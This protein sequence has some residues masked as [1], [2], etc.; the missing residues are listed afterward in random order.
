MPHKVRAAGVTEQMGDIVLQCSGSYPGATLSGNLT[1]FLPVNI[2]NRVDSN[3]LTQDAILLV[4]YGTGFAPSGIPGKVSN[5]NIAFNGLNLTVPPSGNINLKITNLRANASQLGMSAPSKIAASISFTAVL[6]QATVVVAYPLAFFYAT[7]YDRGITCTG[8]PLPTTINLASLFAAQTAFVSTRATEGF[9]GA[10]LTRGST[11]DDGTR[12]LVK[13]SGFPSN[14]HIY[15]P[16]MV[17]G[18]DDY[19]PTAGGD[20]GVPQ[21]VGQYAPGSGTLLLVRVPF[22]DQTG[23]GGFPLATPTGSGP[24]SLNSVSEVPLLNGSGYAVYEV[25]DTN[26]A[27]IE[28]AQFPTFIALASV[29]VPAVAQESISLAPVSSVDVAS[30][31]APIPRFAATIP[32]SDCTILGDCQSSYFPKLSV[33]AAPIILSAFAGGAMNSQPG[34]VP[35]Q[36]QG[37]GVMNWT[38]TPTYKTGSGWLTLDYTSGQNNGSV[39]VWANP[40]GLAAGNYTAAI[41]IDAGPLAGN[42]TVPVTLTVTAITP[43]A[44]PVN[45][46][47]PPST[48]PPAAMAV[49]LVLN[50]ASLAP[51]PLVPGSLATLMGANLAGKKVSVTFDGA[52]ATV[53]Y[54]G[55]GQINLQVPASLGSKM[56]ATMV[57]TVDG[58]ST[59]P[60]VVGLSPAWPAIFSGGVLN[61][62]NSVNAAVAPAKARS[63]LQI[64][65]TGIPDGAAVSVQMAGRK[66]LPPL[67]AGGAPTVPGVQ[68]VNVAVPDDAETGTTQLV[69]CATAGGQQYC[70]PPYSLAVQ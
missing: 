56:S 9:A 6:N 53:L 39:R 24:V 11:E 38:A 57:V 19:V 25:V 2:T 60:V 54:D 52:A 33:Q 21:N 50:A 1:V 66:D 27:V 26:N 58:K 32:A 4:D 65:A 13:Y 23:A 10:F 69:V 37:G 49:T 42:V 59:I 44:P 62:D 12:F 70:S 48:P 35:I 18:S 31:T 43:P 40:T 47:P 51:A 63:V 61:Q 67:Y 36:N 28:S 45:P 64:Y 68:Q 29:T 46:P 34:Y 55:A 5:Q 30:P 20:L 22:A 16:D 17:A 3:N 7:L 15:I 8:S 41:V 14:A